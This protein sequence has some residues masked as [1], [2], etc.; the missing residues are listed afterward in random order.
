MVLEDDITSLAPDF[1]RRLEET[2]LHLPADFDICYLS[3]HGAACDGGQP[4]ELMRCAGPPHIEVRGLF[5]YI[6]SA[7]GA[8]KLSRP[9]DQSP[10]PLERQLDSALSQVVPGLNAW[11]VARGAALLA[12]PSGAC[13]ARDSDSQVVCRCGRCFGSGRLMCGRRPSGGNGSSG[14]WLG[15]LPMMPPTRRAVGVPPPP[16]PPPL[17]RGTRSVSF[18]STACSTPVEDSLH[19]RA[20]RMAMDHFMN[21]CGFPVMWA[22]TGRSSGVC[23]SGVPVARAVPSQAPEVGQW[24]ELLELLGLLGRLAGG[25]GTCGGSGGGSLKV[26]RCG[27]NGPSGPAPCLQRGRRG[28]DRLGASET[29]PEV[30]SQRLLKQA[31]ALLR[32]SRGSF[33]VGAPPC[34]PLESDVED[35]ANYHFDSRSATSARGGHCGGMGPC[36]SAASN[37]RS[38]RDA[39]AAAN[40]RRWDAGARLN[41]SGGGAPKRCDDGAGPKASQWS[42]PSP[43][44]VACEASTTCANSCDRGHQ[45]HN[46]AG[47]SEVREV[48]DGTVSEDL[49]LIGADATPA[50]A[51]AVA[52]QPEPSATRV[53][54]ATATPRRSVANE[55]ARIAAAFTPAEVLGVKPDAGDEELAR[56]WKR[57]LLVIHPDKLSACSEEVR[58]TAAQALEDARK[59]HEELRQTA[60]AAGCVEVPCQPEAD[61]K[62][63]CTGSQPGKRRYELRWQVPG[64]ADATKP[65]EKYE[66]YGPRIF[67]HTGEPM[68]WAL[69][70]TLPRLQ[71][72]FVF[73]EESPSQQEVMW[74][75]DRHR[76]ASVPLTVHAVN[77]R[78]RSEALYFHLPWQKKFPW[79]EGVPSIL[80]RHCCTLQPKL[81]FEPG[82][83]VPCGSCGASLSPNSTAVT[84]R[85]PK[86][87]GEALW[88]SSLGRL[89]CRL[90]GRHLASNPSR[91]Q[92]RTAV[93]GGEPVAGSSAEQRCTSTPPAHS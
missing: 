33:A 71:G 69:L 1:E 35:P 20:P 28:E 11:H 10:F 70:A 39:G 31:G 82:Q 50:D 38:D 92:P 74:A 27:P 19:A 84:V 80:C 54:A 12:S 53:A 14:P 57:L 65:I 62:P 72:C 15:R 36:P 76:V 89:D 23:H 59:A 26:A 83:K 21:P 78:G 66:V 18:T 3:F 2:L 17:S 24:P 40:V 67:A 60:Q 77:G 88:D 47:K 49:G 75:G 79:L 22:A 41:G 86:C 64:V 34:N 5:G 30:S 13:A 55:A 42:T 48:P 25:S 52:D 44:G 37:A 6:V 90:C 29:V 87:H 73:V 7:A 51:A 4:L 68:E 16:E 81:S 43:A 58:A 8:A 93:S 45:G 32:G 61:G 46:R 91:K 9:G 85:C 56:A 63:T